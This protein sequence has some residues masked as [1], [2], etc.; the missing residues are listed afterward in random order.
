MFFGIYYFIVSL[1]LN[2][3]KEVDQQ[4]QSE[5]ISLNNFD[6]R[7]WTQIESGGDNWM[8]MYGAGAF[9]KV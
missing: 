6:T 4:N 9:N 7:L 3:V 5:D 8:T 2:I 1:T